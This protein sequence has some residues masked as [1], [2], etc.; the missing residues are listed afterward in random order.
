MPRRPPPVIAWQG[1]AYRAT[2]YDVPLWVHPNR[3]DGRWN[4]AGVGCTQYFCL[5][6]DAPFAE[7]IRHEN[8]RTEEEVATYRVG[9]WQA[10]V[11]EAAIVD[12]STFEKAES[13][14]FPP[15]ALVEDDH[16]R[17]QAE[18]EW[19]REQGL[20]GLLSPSAALPGS[21]SLTLFGPRVE[22]PFANERQLS[23]EMPVHRLSMASPPEGL[24]QRVRFFG[25]P[26]PGA[27]AAPA[28]V[29]RRRRRPR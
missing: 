28:T 21:L 7:Q 1:L 12:Y 16:D 25:E 22:I 11:D 13:A 27:P 18:A 4:V 15:E 2:T 19:L 24:V 29:R 14:G 3:R 9:L 17:C 20:A 6:P 23:A 8:L 26:Y 5:D 10:K